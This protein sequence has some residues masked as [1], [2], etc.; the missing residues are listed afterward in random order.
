MSN[1]SPAAQATES[2]TGPVLSVRDLKTSFRTPTGWVEIV[3]GI[4]FDIAP[5][6]TLAVVG[7]SGSGK[8]VTALSI[9][10]LLDPASSR[11]QGSVSLAGRE[12]TSLPE[13]QMRLI[14]GRQIGMIFQ[15][16]LTSLNPIASV[17][18]QIA[19]V[20]TIHGEQS[21]QVAMAEAVRL[22]ERVRI[23]AARSRARDLPHTLSG[24]MR[25]RVMI[26]MALACKPKVL[27]ADE[28]TTALD[29]TI[30]A[31]ILQLIKQL[32]DEEGMGVLFITHDMG[33]VAEIAD[34]TVVMLGGEVIEEGPT[35]AIFDHSKTAYTKSLIAA[36]PKLGGELN[37]QPQ[38]F[39]LIDKAT[40]TLMVATDRPDTVQREGSPALSVRNLVKRFD[41]PSGFFG[42]IG[43]RVHAVE[44]V[45]FDI[46]PGETLSLVGESG[47]GKS[48]TGRAIM[49]L[50]EP[51]SGQVLIDGTQIL[52]LDKG[53]MR[54]MRRHIQMIFQDP[55]ASLNPRIRIGEAIA[56]PYLTHKL[57]TREQARAVVL[58]LLER[59][60][61][62]PQVANRYPQQFSGGQRQRICIARA[63]SLSPKVIVADESVSG[64]D[65]SIK[66]QVV[67]LLLDL[68]QQLGLSYLFI[69][70][71]MA[72]VE[73]VSHRVA[74]MYLG[75]IVEIGP[76]GAVFGNP[77]HPYTKRLIAAVPVPD[78]AR[79]RQIRQP[80]NSEIKSPIRAVDYATPKRTYR[81]LGAGHLVQDWGSD[82]QLGVS[83][84]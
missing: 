73:R 21:R 44:D 7:E 38:H 49:R 45:S 76:A 79:R 56:E 39:P 34:R 30:Q 60:G 8:S 1:S 82:W 57:G 83:E 67:N 75:E 26:A 32:Q 36:V 27:I 46:M 25:Q 64:L 40:G 55:F 6:Q 53:R 10:R 13:A 43:G 3:K 54:D 16:A 35:Q 61:M 71:D 20:L 59:V 58:D 80:D 12:L 24:G 4:S 63:L 11:I 14:R 17:G 78:P 66:A 77:Q 51:Q 15:E 68:Q 62:D 72:V 37:G 22:L 70:H 81:D 5:R 28:P 74:V 42:A 31:Q 18:E 69:S 19:E 50:S 65:V 48:T 29:V 9:M 33:V 52:G 23:P 2:L 41:I 84:A 47:C